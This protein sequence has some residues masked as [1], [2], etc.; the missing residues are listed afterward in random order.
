VVPPQVQADS[1]RARGSNGASV[2][3]LN[4]TVRRHAGDC[5]VHEK[6]NWISVAVASI[7]T[8]LV[9][10][11]WYSAALFGKR[12]TEAMGQGVTKPG[13]PAKVFGLAYIFSFIAASMLATLMSPSA[14]LADGLRLGALVGASFVAASFGINYQFANRP[15]SALFI[16]GGYSIVQFSL[17]GT[18]LGAWP[19]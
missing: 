10:G 17:M 18:V 9:G 15:W 6:I 3:P 16:D 7:A 1:V 11:P 13:H 2:R 5:T 4:F 14:T 12:W 19:K 8:F